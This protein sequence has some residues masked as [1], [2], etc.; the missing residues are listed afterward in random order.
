[1]SWLSK[2]E[3]NRKIQKAL[4]SLAHNG[5]EQIDVVIQTGSGQSIKFE[6]FKPRVE[7][8]YAEIP[9]FPVSRAQ[10][11]EG[12]LRVFH[13]RGRNFAHLAG[14]AHF[15]EGYEGWELGIPIR[16]LRELGAKDIV[17]T[18]A[19]GSLTNEFQVGD[20]VLIEDFIEICPSFPLRGIEGKNLSV[21]FLP[22]AGILNE[23]LAKIMYLAAK[24]KM[25]SLK[26]GI[27]AMTAGPRYETF[28]EIKAL[29]KL[30]A[31]IVGM[32]TLPE[33]ITALSLGMRTIAISTVSNLA[34]EKPA[35]HLEVLRA[36][37][38]VSVKLS[39]LIEEFI[40][41]YFAGETRHG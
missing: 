15:Y 17:L 21:E 1:M 38:E 10:G 34:F 13:H 32:S 25:I 20:F 31:N 7:I 3:L 16:V 28:A 5:I 33:L 37:K 35:N 41:K 18:N 27:Y 26:K 24:K 4:E 36:S 2:D 12:L 29:K 22:M 14:R 9:F 11:H 23:E 39:S 8:A 30:G 6:D 40:L 19:S